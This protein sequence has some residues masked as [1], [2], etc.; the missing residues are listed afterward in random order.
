MKKDKTPQNIN[1]LISEIGERMILFRLYALISINPHLDIFKNYSEPGF[2]IGVRNSDTG[3][4]VK[5]EVK[6]RQHLVTT[7]AEKNK[8]TCHFT[9]TE[10]ERNC[11]DFLIGYWIEQNDFFI[12][13]SPCLTKTKSGDKFLYKFVCSKLKS[14]NKYSSASMRYLNNWNQILELAGEP[15][16]YE[17]NNQNMEYKRSKKTVANRLQ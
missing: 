1:D 5:I 4:K 17:R 13:P 6:T 11:A 7:T 8:N 10:N 14:G 3:R 9:L 15:S 2:D 12:V 16:S